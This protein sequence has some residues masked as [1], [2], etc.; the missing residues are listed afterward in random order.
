[1]STET[2]NLYARHSAPGSG[3]PLF[4]AALVNFRFGGGRLPIPPLHSVY[5]H[6]K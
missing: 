4:Q 1:M 3:I 5:S 2:N 6:A